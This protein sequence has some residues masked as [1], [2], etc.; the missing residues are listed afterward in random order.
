M[1]TNGIRVSL[2]NITGGGGGGGRGGAKHNVWGGQ[3]NCVITLHLGGSGG[4]P[5]TNILA[6][7]SSEIESDIILINLGDITIIFSTIVLQL[8]CT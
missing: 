8:A 2:R 6:C 4:M 5:P 7:R 1:D 3:L